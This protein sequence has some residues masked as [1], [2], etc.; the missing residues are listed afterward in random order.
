MK[1]L[2]AILLAILMLLVLIPAAGAAFS[3]AES[4]SANRKVAV[5][6]AVENGIITGFPDGSFQ[7]KVT[8]TRAQAA[9]I[10]CVALEGTGGADALTK[11]DCGF[12]DVSASHWAS[13]L[14]A[15]CVDKGIVAG[16]GNGKFN[17]NGN[18]TSAAFAKMLLV[19]YGLASA[20]QLTG[21][22]WATETQRIM[23]EKGL[24]LGADP[25]VDSMTTRE[26]A[27]Q[28]VYN[29]RMGAEL[30]QVDEDGYKK[31]TVF[32]D[33]SGKYRL[34]GRA[35]QT[36]DG[37]ICD[38]SAD[39]IEFTADCKGAIE[40]A[41]NV[42]HD[43]TSNHTTFRA[44]VDG[45]VGNQLV[46]KSSGKHTDT[47]YLDVAP[48]EHTIRIVK[49]YEVSQSTD[50]LKSVT[51]TCKPDTVKPTAQKEKLI[52]FI[53][54]SDTTG[55]GLI[56][57]NTPDVTNN[58]ASAV[59]SYGY[60]TADAMDMDYE[61][62]AKRSAGC[63]K[64]AGKPTAYNYQDMFEY[65]N[66]WRDPSTKYSFTR[67]A[68][69]IVL[70][71]SGN[72]KTFSAEETSA[73]LK[74][75]IQTLRKYHGEKTPVIIFFTESTTHRPV[76]EALVAENPELKGVLVLYNR[77]GMG[78]HSTPDAHVGYAEEVLKVLRPLMEGK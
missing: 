8:L 27:C 15:Y 11:T 21:S 29:V 3:D 28:L 42:S 13:K 59:L 1:Q 63:L 4:I 58:S 36:K 31:V 2:T 62:V 14:V 73:A 44:I 67:K 50:M 47:V 71:V 17:P 34:L 37:V 65:Q 10:L 48:G 43:D 6:Y 45:T 30:A 51:L 57:T 22:K 24:D 78:G 35:L 18:L 72:D 25:I 66:R 46:I 76:A 5:D 75:Y 23:S 12:S 32:F 64:K 60:L 70:K 26:N 68:D 19:A 55:F 16:V 56:T 7:P 52:L 61:I 39:G 69:A 53:G 49:D 20:D 54:D 41:V 9:K 74:S 77:D 33:D 40:L 38:W